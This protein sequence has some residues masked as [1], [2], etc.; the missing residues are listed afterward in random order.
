M[1][2]QSSLFVR[3]KHVVGLVPCMAVE[4]SGRV[5]S[6]LVSGGDLVDGIVIDL[7]RLI[8]IKKHG[9]CERM[10]WKS[11]E[12]AVEPHLP[13][14]DGLVPE[15]TVS[16]GA[17]LVFQLPHQGLQGNQVFFFGLELI[18]PCHEMSGADIVEVVVLEFIISDDT[19]FGDHGVG[20]ELAIIIDVLS[21]VGQI[22]VEH[23]F[24]L[25]SH[26]IAPFRLGGEVE[27][28]ALRHPLHL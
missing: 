6:A 26:H 27:H 18:H 11:H 25:D 13:R 19:L 7:P 21:T 28:I 4:R 16:L 20:V 9:C 23:G 1:L 10:E 2:R 3:P 17:R 14:I 15:H 5:K 12:D 8:R 24:Q 22:G